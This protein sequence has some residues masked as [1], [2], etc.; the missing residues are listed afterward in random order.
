MKKP[1]I[2]FLILAIAIPFV[3]SAN[4]LDD[5][6]IEQ[7]SVIQN[8]QQ[9]EQNKLRQ[10][11][12]KEIE[13]EQKKIIKQEN[14]VIENLADVKCFWITKIS[15]TKNNIF[16][17]VEEKSFIRNYVNQ[18]LT[19]N[20]INKLTQEISSDL[21]KR[22]YVTSKAILT[23]EEASGELLIEIVEGHMEDLIFNDES[24]FDKMQ[25][26]SAFGVVKK[27]EI[28]NLHNV[29]KG[30][31]QINRLSSNKAVIKV[32]AGSL[33]NS[34]IVAV[35]NKPQNTIRANIS[36]DDLGGKTTGKNRDTIGISFDNLLHLNDNLNISRS[37]N[38]LT[39]K[40][41]E[42]ANS[43]LNFSWSAPL[44]NNTLMLSSTRYH[45]S[46]RQGSVVSVKAHGESITN[47]INLETKLIK[48]DRYRLSSGLNLTNRN[49][50]NYADDVKLESS[51]R[52]SSIGS[53]S[54]VNTFF[55]DAATLFIKP[56][57]N[58]GL[59]ILN[60]KKDEANIS[61]QAGHA[62]FEAFKLYVNY[63]HSLEIPQILIPFNYSLTFDGQFSKQRL[64]SNDQFFIGGPYTVRGFESGSI[65]GDS[66]Y[67]IKNELKF[68]IGKTVSRLV[69]IEKLKYFPAW[70]NNISVAPFYDYGNVRT[71]DGSQS[72]KLSGSGFRTS[73]NH[74]NFTANLT[75]A[76]VNNK[77]YL[78]Q[79]KYSENQ[80]VYFD[81]TSEFGFF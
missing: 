29:E 2:I 43:S 76:W 57:Y 46:L 59:K 70:I 78:L 62:Q 7:N 28:L 75:C 17:Q 8:Q 41:E 77:S 67:T 47:A 69:N 21:A 60:A 10:G 23:K 48:K 26:F 61:S 79:D 19:L 35:Q 27:N 12:L 36:F 1:V 22:G 72:G 58:R 39:K 31:D 80:A 33:K 34:S 42:G 16:S 13:L 14:E 64:Y 37:A 56:S 5:I 11:E 63:S 81:I 49:V 32:F 44:K 15:F 74:K 54:L 20:K 30:L 40:K 18:C 9:F 24:F 71:R 55:F 51:S 3:S 52:R 65:A 25:K 45:Y 4:E 6:I 38:D 50:I 73:F 53:L 66:G 68:N